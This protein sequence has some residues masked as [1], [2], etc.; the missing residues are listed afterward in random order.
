MNE[1]Q[2]KMKALKHS[3]PFD[4]LRTGFDRLRANGGYPELCGE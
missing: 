2:R 4:K 3:P 1:E